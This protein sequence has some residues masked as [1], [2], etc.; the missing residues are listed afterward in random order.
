MSGLERNRWFD[1][2]DKISVPK[3][4]WRE[5]L[6]LGME[7]RR[8]SSAWVEDARAWISFNSLPFLAAFIDHAPNRIRHNVRRLELHIVTAGDDHLLPIS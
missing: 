6:T 3:W 5:E 7:P 4:E 8:P 1:P 2:L